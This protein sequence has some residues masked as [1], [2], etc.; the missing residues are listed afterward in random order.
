MMKPDLASCHSIFLSSLCISLWI[1]SKL[2][3]DF[4]I[5]SYKIVFWLYF[6]TA[7]SF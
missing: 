3:L 2:T 6:I 1:A 5:K 7:L 4:V